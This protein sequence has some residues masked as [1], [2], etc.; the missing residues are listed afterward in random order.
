MINSCDAA[1]RHNTQRDMARSPPHQPLAQFSFLYEIIT[2]QSPRAP[3]LA[4]TTNPSPTQTT[5]PNPPRPKPSHL[6][7]A[8][9][10]TATR[11]DGTRNE[12]GIS[13][14]WETGSSAGKA[15]SCAARSQLRVRVDD[16]RGVW[17]ARG[18]AAAVTLLRL[19]VRGVPA[20]RP[21]WELY[22]DP[23]GAI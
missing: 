16:V 10:C 3:L 2:R 9:A 8:P 23:V 7:S 19:A 15:A 21:P 22:N 17:T 20:S 4:T 12:A 5:R 11:N 13:A 1:N 18:Q 14:R 6:T